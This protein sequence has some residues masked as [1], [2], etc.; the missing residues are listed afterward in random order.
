M[1]EYRALKLKVRERIEKADGMEA[2]VLEIGKWLMT[3]IPMRDHGWN[4]RHIH[5]ELKDLKER[6]QDILDISARLQTTRYTI[7]DGSREEESGESTQESFPKS[8]LSG[9]NQS[10]GPG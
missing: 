9:R 10:T 4:L 8:F 1:K 6:V 5:I 2:Q 7:V 3:Y